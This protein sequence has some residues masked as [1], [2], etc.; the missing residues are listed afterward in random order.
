MGEMFVAR[1]AFHSNRYPKCCVFVLCWGEGP[2]FFNTSAWTPLIFFKTKVFPYYWL[3]NAHGVVK[4][5]TSHVACIYANMSV[6]SH[7][8]DQVER[9]S[10]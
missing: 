2:R 1:C 10:E 7:Q 4:E 5:S 6:A 8:E 9:V 3:T